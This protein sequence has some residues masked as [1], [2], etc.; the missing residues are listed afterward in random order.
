MESPDRYRFNQSPRDECF[1]GLQRCV[2]VIA[3]KDY[4]FGTFVIQFVGA[5]SPVDSE[6]SSEG[7]ANEILCP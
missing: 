1:T 7:T 6:G 5:I 3:T 2:I 4:T